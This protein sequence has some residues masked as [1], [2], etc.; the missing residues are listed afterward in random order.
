MVAAAT[1][2]ALIW[3]IPSRS[4]RT[5]RDDLRARIEATVSGQSVVL[6]EQIRRE[7]LGVE[8]SLR[9]LKAAFQA[10]PDH[11][12]I[13]AWREQMPALTDV[14]EDAFILDEQFII[15]HD[16]NPA[17]VGLSI[18][19]GVAS[20]FG[21]QTDKPDPY[22]DLLIEP[23]TQ[24]PQ[25]RQ[26]VSLMMLRLDHPS[27]WLVGVN[28]RTG[29]LRRLFTEANLGLQGMTALIDT[30]VGRVQAIVGPAAA[31]PNYDI[32]ASA[33]YAAMQAR[34]DGTWIG[35]SAP[36]GVQRI[37]A[38]RRIPGHQ[39]AVVVAV[40]EA[41]AMRPATLWAQDV[42]SVAIAATLV[43]LVA[44]GIALYA[45]WT[46]REERRLRQ[47]LE[48][49]RILVA[50]AQVEL[51]EARARLGG[52]A[53]QLGALF[54]GI[55]EGALVLDAEL[56][57]TEWNRRFPVLFGVAPANLQRG[58]PLDELLRTQ[59][60]D[61]AFGPLDDIEDEVATRLAQLRRANGP[62]RCSMARRVDAHWR[63]SPAGTPTAVCCWWCVK[64][65]SVTCT[66]SRTAGRGGPER[67]TDSGIRRDALTAVK[68]L[69]RESAADFVGWRRF[70][71]RRAL[72]V[73]GQTRP[74][75]RPPR[76]PAPV[77]MR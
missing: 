17:E 62:C 41:A 39:F 46:F 11:F 43:V 71:G 68:S 51:A 56:R 36:D 4:I 50:N 42:R 74:I 75:G 15:R 32:A 54:A 34:P 35:A 55:D 37:H 58:L 25:T 40:D 47:N 16:F 63:Y 69:V 61:G 65:P 53:S 67:V 19:S 73:A 52:S 1:L 38:F 20:M 72:Q 31:N 66:P 28:Y 6:A 12:D 9:I 13:S 77:T 60:R 76:C 26:H 59:A 30:R 5:E 57:L 21:P 18:G 49:E 70:P 14:V 10:N 27:G 2:I 24:K 29:A 8:Q 33:M 48:R 45:V 64:R 44:M 23:N 22:G 3:L 7:M